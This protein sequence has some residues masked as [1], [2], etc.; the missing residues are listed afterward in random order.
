MRAALFSRR[1][2]P[3]AAM[4]RAESAGEKRLRPR[5]ECGRSRQ[6]HDERAR[7][8]LRQRYAEGVSL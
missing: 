2:S 4:H 6:W 3:P 1:L 5:G 8:Y 7:Y